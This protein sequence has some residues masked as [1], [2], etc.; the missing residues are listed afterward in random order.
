M[1]GG[2]VNGAATVVARFFTHTHT[3]LYN[4][5][6]H[7]LFKP[8][9]WKVIIKWGLF[10]NVYSSYRYHSKNLER[11]TSLLQGVK[12]QTNGG[13]ATLRSLLSPKDNW[14]T[15]GWSR[16][17][18]FFF[19]FFSFILFVASLIAVETA[20]SLGAL[21]TL[22]EDPGLSPSTHTELSELQFLGIWTP[23]PASLDTV[24]ACLCAHTLRQNIHTRKVKKILNYFMCECFL[25]VCI[26]SVCLLGACR[27]QKRAAAILQ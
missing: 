22:T 16:I 11:L 20:E 24:C 17:S 2:S 4:R 1:G 14:S 23:L 21:A 19:F 27:G 7:C 15:R 12:S 13:T 18:C 9:K 8:G 3:A 6:S 26:C 10:P 5:S 25:Y